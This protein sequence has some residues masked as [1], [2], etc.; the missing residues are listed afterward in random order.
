M[1]MLQSKRLKNDG[2]LDAENTFAAIDNLQVREYFSMDSRETRSSLIDPRIRMGH[3][4][5]STKK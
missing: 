3:P 4:R 5:G 1:G 2:F